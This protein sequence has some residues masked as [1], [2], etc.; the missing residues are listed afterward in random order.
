M[1]F[2][3][4][5]LLFVIGANDGTRPGSARIDSVLFRLMI[6]TLIGSLV[7]AAVGWRQ[8]VKQPE[9]YPRGKTVAILTLALGGALGLAILF[10]T[11]F[12]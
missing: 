1:A 7:L 10:T 12:Q 8:C 11:T 2:L 3:G 9:R 4:A 6:P 5:A